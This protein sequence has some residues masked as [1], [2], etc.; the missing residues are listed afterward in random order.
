MGAYTVSSRSGANRGTVGS[1]HFDLT[2]L[3]PFALLA[4]GPCPATQLGSASK[5]LPL[6]LTKLHEMALV[7]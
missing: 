2:V 3:L 5:I 1:D 6:Q 4:G 7:N